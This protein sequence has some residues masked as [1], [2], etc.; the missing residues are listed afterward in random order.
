MDQVTPRRTLASQRD[1]DPLTVTK[2]MDFDTIETR[3]EGKETPPPKAHRSESVACNLFPLEPQS[4]PATKKKRGRP[5]KV[6]KAKPRPPV[7][8]AFA[9]NG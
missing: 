6:S 1:Q 5:K 4:S 3:M 7:L 8:P 2:K 9:A